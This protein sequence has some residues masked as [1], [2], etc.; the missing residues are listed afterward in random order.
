MAIGLPLGGWAAA[1]QRNLPYHA[2][3]GIAYGLRRNDAIASITLNPAKMMGL[4]KSLAVWRMEKKQL[5]LAVRVISS[6]LEAVL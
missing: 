5:F 4:S 3:H 6:I 1:N 2:G